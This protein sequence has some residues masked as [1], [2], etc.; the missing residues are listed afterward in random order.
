MMQNEPKM[1]LGSI[2]LRQNS[3]K[4]NALVYAARANCQVRITLGPSLSG[5]KHVLLHSSVA[6]SW[7]L[8]RELSLEQMLLLADF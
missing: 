8:I 2:S 5:G 3:V 7:P 1:S 6:V 4:Q